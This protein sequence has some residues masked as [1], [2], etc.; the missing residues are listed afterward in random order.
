M[1]AST[2]G[3]LSRYRSAKAT[4]RRQRQLAAAL[5]PY[6][7]AVASV[8]H[9][10]NNGVISRDVVMSAVVTTSIGWRRYV[11]P[12]AFI[13]GRCDECYVACILSLL[14]YHL[15]CPI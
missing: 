3:L 1:A 10:K 9:R 4:R 8:Y 2:W 5:S 15:I 14:K 13:I 12:R 7:D 6:N 11:P